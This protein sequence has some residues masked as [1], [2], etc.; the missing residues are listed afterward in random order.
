MTSVTLKCFYA[1]N[2]RIYWA[3][4][5]LQKS[6]CYPKNKN[7]FAE[8]EKSHYPAG[9]LGALEEEADIASSL[10]ELAACY[11]KAPNT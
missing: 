3:I 9:I 11:P 8:I 5:L 2:L 10:P 4:S 7:C 6:G 1:A